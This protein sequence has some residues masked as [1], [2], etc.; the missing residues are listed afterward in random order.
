[1]GNG[2]IYFVEG[3][4]DAYARD[5]IEQDG[6]TYAFDDGQFQRVR[7]RGPGGKDGVLLSRSDYSGRLQ[8]GNVKTWRPVNSRVMVGLD[9][10]FRP[11]PADLSRPRM[12]DSHAV[13][14]GDENKWLAPIAR[15]LTDEGAECAF[16]CSLDVDQHGNWYR[17]GVEQRFEDLWTTACDLWDQLWD[18]QQAGKAEFTFDAELDI[19]VE[20]LQ[21]NYRIGKSECALLGLFDDHGKQSSVLMALADWPTVEERMK[22]K[23]SEQA[24][25]AG[26]TDKPST[27]SLKAGESVAS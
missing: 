5:Y 10:S 6:L 14:L 25:P 22:K 9:P 12:F 27:S 1:M 3:R 18:N 2:F 7:T 24:L 16:P 13:V 20:C 23:R 8:P 15:R 26:T 21:L 17:R 4:S 19:I 11:A